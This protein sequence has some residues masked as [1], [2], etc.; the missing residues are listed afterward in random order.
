MPLK[1]REVKRQVVK[2]EEG[3]ALQTPDNKPMSLFK[4]AM[5]PAI[6][7]NTEQFVFPKSFLVVQADRVAE[8][9]KNKETG[10]DLKDSNGNKIKTGNFNVRLQLS[11]GD[12]AQKL[13]DAGLELD[14]LSTIQ[15][16]VKADKPLQNFVPNESLVKLI[17]PV[18]MLGF[19][20]QQADRI[21]LVAE[22]CELV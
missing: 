21:I 4:S 6:T 7:L 22:D 9:K 14:G 8:Y 12:A 19:G 2:I 3:N 10:W 20:G 1:R 16:T 17:K 18:V 15:C 13:V 11:D 5:L